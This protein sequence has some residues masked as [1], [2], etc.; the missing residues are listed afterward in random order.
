MI[1]MVTVGT[2]TDLD[3]K[4]QLES[5]ALASTDFGTGRAD[6]LCMQSDGVVHGYLNKGVNNMV[7]VGLIKHAEGKERKSAY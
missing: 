7:N 2:H 6:F 4:A 5:K 3:D 1:L